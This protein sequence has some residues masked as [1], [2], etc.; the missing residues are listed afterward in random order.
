[1]ATK[2]LI[3]NSTGQVKYESAF[4]SPAPYDISGEAAGTPIVNTNIFDFK[5]PRAFTLKS[6]GHVADCLTAPS[7][8]TVFTIKLN[9]SSIGTITYTSAGTSGTVAI[10]SGTDTAIAVGDKI[11]I[12]SPA[13]S[14]NSIGTPFWTLVGTYP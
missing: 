4:I 3:D 6:S 11:S 7:G 10:T 5:A 8:S 9:G 1:M 2:V 12:T 13:A 14:L